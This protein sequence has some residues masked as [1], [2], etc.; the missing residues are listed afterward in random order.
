MQVKMIE[1]NEIPFKKYLEY[2]NDKRRIYN[3]LESAYT[4]DSCQNIKF[5]INNNYLIIKIDLYLIITNINEEY[6][7]KMEV[8]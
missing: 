1:I 8:I 4:K 2:L 3:A 5:L 7:Y 6:F